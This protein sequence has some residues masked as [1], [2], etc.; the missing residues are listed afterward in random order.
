MIGTSGS[1]KTHVAEALATLLGLRYV[2]NDAI[3]W[4]AGWQPAPPDEVYAAIDAATRE[5]GWTFDGNLGPSAGDRLVLGRCD[6]LVWLDL[7][8]REV[9]WQIIRR[10]LARTIG[11]EPLWHGNS[12]RWRTLLSADSMIWWSIKTFSRRRGAYARLFA[13]PRYAGVIRVR[14]RGRGELDRWLQ[15]LRPQSPKQ[16]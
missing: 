15:S 4:R 9:W 3:I 8:R 1:G 5:D 14:L 10:T 12:E 13:D 11:R 7:P 16:S 2:C 6:T